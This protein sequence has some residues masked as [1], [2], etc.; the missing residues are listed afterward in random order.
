L[1]P[2]SPCRSATVNTPANRRMPIALV[3]SSRPN[4]KKRKNNKANDNYKEKVEKNLK[5]EIYEKT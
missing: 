1:R 5:K 4:K 3:V 2:H